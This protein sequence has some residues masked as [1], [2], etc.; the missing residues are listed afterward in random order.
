MQTRTTNSGVDTSTISRNNH[1]CAPDVSRLILKYVLFLDGF[2]SGV[3]I[4]VSLIGRGIKVLMCQDFKGENKCIK[5]N[6]L[7]L[8]SWPEPQWVCQC[9]CWNICCE[10]SET[11][12][13][14][15]V[16]R[17]NSVCCHSAHHRGV[18]VCLCGWVVMRMCPRLKQKINKYCIQ[19]PI[20]IISIT[21]MCSALYYNML[22]YHRY[23]A[24]NNVT[25]T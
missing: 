11:I 4:K 5:K 17:K 19:L 8:S 22:K 6:Q 10:A 14:I 24:D 7:W 18:T 12:G 16:Y 25:D 20:S 13:E 21:V 9:L 1:L 15:N 2:A 23:N 3:W